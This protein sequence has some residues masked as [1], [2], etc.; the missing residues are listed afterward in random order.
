MDIKDRYVETVSKIEASNSLKEKIYSEVNEMENKKG[1]R[2]GFLLKP[3]LTVLFLAVLT[4]GVYATNVGGIRTN[5]N[6]FLYGEATQVTVEETEPGNFKL[7]YP[8]GTER[9]TGGM[10][11]DGKGGW[12]P[13][14]MEEIIEY[15]N[16][17]P[18]LE[19]K[20]DGTALFFY[21]DYVIDITEDLKDDNKA[22]IQIKDGFLGKNF[23]VIMDENGGY[24]I[25]G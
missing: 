15:I 21:H 2:K 16:N 10:S 7:T 19:V 11:E 4:T 22:T 20:E 5:V 14:T 17:S 8:D 24:S 3:I 18:E 23:T 13:V 1:K 6:S 25:R 12:R 9:V